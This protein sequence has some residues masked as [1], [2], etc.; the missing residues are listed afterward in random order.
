MAHS[1]IHKGKTT[2]YCGRPVKL[3]LLAIMLFN[4]SAFIIM[5]DDTVKGD[6]LRAPGARAAGMGGAFT[7]V[8]DDYSAFFWNPAGLVLDN[9]ISGTLLYDSV[10]RNKENNGGFNYTLPVYDNYTA[11]FSYIK[12]TYD[13]SG[14]EDDTLYFTGAAWLDDDKKYAVGG[15]FKFMNTSVANYNV[16]GRAASFDVGVMV[17]PDML[18]KKIRFGFLAQDLDAVM[19]WNNGVNQDIPY[20]FKMGTSY[21][22][23]PTAVVDLDI[24]ILQSEASRYHSR[25]GIN[26]GGEKWFM[27]RIVGNFG[28]RAG[29]AWREAFNPDY[30]FTFGLSYAREDFTLDYAYAPGVDSL[31]ETHKLGFTY[32]FGTRESLRQAEQATQTA[33][34]AVTGTAGVDAALMLEKFRNMDMSITSK[35]FSP[36]NDGVMDSV[37]YILRNNPPDYKGID[38]SFIVTNQKNAVVKTLKG[39]GAL[40][41]MFTWRGDNDDAVTASDGDYTATL[42]V[43][44]LGT[45]LWKK[46]RV[47]TLDNTA[48][49]FDVALSPKVF[50]PTKGSSI[51]ELTLDI[52][53]KAQDIK[54]WQLVIMDDQKHSIRKMSG[55]GLTARLSWGGKDALDNPV[56]DGQYSA[57]VTM[58]DYAGNSSFVSEPFTVDTRVAEIKIKSDPKMFVPGKEKAVFSL[59]F[60]EPQLVKSY[61]FEIFGNGKKPIKAFANRTVAMKKIAWDGTDDSS[62]QVRKG[63]AYRYHVTVQQKNGIRNTEEGVIQTSLPEFKDAGIEL[64]LAAIDFTAGDSTIPAD[65]NSSLNQAAEAVKKYAK[66]Y[67]VYVKAYSTDGGGADGNMKLSITRAEAVRDYLVAAGVAEANI[68]AAGYGDCTYVGSL[69]KDEL[70]KEGKRVEVELLTK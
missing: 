5:A 66:E 70:A 41:S 23:D 50:A 22:F 62:K 49:A 58:Y 19:V 43:N 47:V 51:K 8:A 9:N 38:W 61:D 25:T 40:P 52:K 7:A 63:A 18:E 48:P 26:I 24:D 54:S 44:Y 1:N 4:F 57:N 17:F 36:N 16:Y 27:N 37:D 34:A 39:T 59:D 64:T 69:T 42:T 68:Y 46:S 3:I 67:Y 28:L 35:Y 55:D 32:Y 60:S 13:S 30:N 45:E 11:A 20:L 65:E 2:G 12:S 15:N 56:K 14:Y 10:F 29:F 21:T 31:G 33:A 53:T 6:I